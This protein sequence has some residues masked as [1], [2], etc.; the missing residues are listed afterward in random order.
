[1]W[2]LDKDE[3]W[4]AIGDLILNQLLGMDIPDEQIKNMIK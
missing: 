1:M 3:N 4:E 2:H